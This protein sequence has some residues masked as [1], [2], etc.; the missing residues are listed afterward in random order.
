MENPVS[1]NSH[2]ERFDRKGGE[3]YR[4]VP[5]EVAR[6]F[7]TGR[8]P[9]RV[10]CRHNNTVDFQCDNTFYYFGYLSNLFAVII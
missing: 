10:R 1:F 6:Q 3:L 8:K 2:L 7:V 5:E 4:L 9:E